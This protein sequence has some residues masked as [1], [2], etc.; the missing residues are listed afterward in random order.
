MRIDQIVDPSVFEE[1]RLLVRRQGKASHLRAE[2][3]Q[4]DCRP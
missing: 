1:R 4:P 2:R 3:Y